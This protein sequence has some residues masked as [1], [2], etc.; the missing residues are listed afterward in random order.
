MSHLGGPVDLRAGPDGDLFYLDIWDGELRRIYWGQPGVPPVN[1]TPRPT[2]TI[3]TPTVEQTWAVGDTVGFSGHAVDSDGAA[4]PP[5]ALHWSYNLLHC[6]TETSCH[7][8]PIQDYGGIASGS[9]VALDHEY[10]ARIELVLTATNP[11]GGKD[12]TAVVLDP[13]TTELTFA[14]NPAGFVLTAGDTTEAA[15][16]TKRVIVGS[17]SLVS[18]PS[19][20]RRPGDLIDWYWNAWSDGGARTHDVVAGSTPVT[21][22]ATYSQTP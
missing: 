12:S 8:H 4:L 2:A 11:A 16:F 18:A 21:Y 7:R 13:R 3:D 15:P 10:P 5:S 20:Q 9:V 6:S 1:N 17:D 19:P 14:S 22:T